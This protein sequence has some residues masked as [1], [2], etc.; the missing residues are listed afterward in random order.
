M[1]NLTQR[2][3]HL[4]SFFPNQGTFFDFRKRA[5]ETSPLVVH[6]IL[7][8]SKQQALDI[9]MMTQEVTFKLVFC[10]KQVTSSVKPLE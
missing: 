3:I 9:T 4:G 1:E 6:L 7:H 10:I 2:G 5:G 8:S